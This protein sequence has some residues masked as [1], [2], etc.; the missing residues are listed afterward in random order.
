MTDDSGQKMSSDMWKTLKNCDVRS[1]RTRNI[2][3]KDPLLM[4]NEVLLFKKN[5]ISK[6]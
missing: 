1:L 2:S 3:V 5:H 4:L 6:N